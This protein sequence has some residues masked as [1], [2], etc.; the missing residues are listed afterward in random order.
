MSDPSKNDTEMLPD[1][2]SEPMRRQ[3]IL[4]KWIRE[5]GKDIATIADE[6][7]LAKV[8]LY[9]LHRGY[10]PISD[11]MKMRLETAFNKTM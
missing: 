4:R 1:G 6:K 3:L 7:K 9:H 2:I 11:K 8:T 10:E 5:E